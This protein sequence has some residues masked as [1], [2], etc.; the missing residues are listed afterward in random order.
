[1]TLFSK[2][3]LQVYVIKQIINKY[4]AQGISKALE[5]NFCI[6]DPK[7]NLSPKLSTGGEQQK[8]NLKTL[9]VC[10]IY[11]LEQKLEGQFSIMVL[12]NNRHKR[13]ITGGEFI[14]TVF[15]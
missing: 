6:D 11:A 1:L 8:L 4:P 3:V 5:R 14:V 7:E 10:F 13:Q 9:H 12:L 15:H 2:E